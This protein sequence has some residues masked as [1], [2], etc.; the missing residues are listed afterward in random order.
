MAANRYGKQK[1][2]TVVLSPDRRGAV[3]VLCRGILADRA[4]EKIGWSQAG[5]QWVAPEGYKLKQ[6]IITLYDRVPRGVKLFAFTFFDRDSGKVVTVCTGAA[7]KEKMAQNYMIRAGWRR[8][9]GQW[10]AP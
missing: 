4:L 5:S 3:M 7:E 1:L 9:A 2:S 8:I 6:V 10:V